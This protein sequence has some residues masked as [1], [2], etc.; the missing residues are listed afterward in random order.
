MIKEH[1][2]H[3]VVT[4][5]HLEK[6]DDIEISREFLDALIQIEV[7]HCTLSFLKGV[8]TLEAETSKVVFKCLA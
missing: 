3:D 8:L 6:I 5:D 7:C 2:L 4:F 1:L